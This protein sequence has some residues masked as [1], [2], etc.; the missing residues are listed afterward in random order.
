MAED[1]KQ[2]SPEEV[3]ERFEYRRPDDAGVA[4]ITKIREACKVLAAVITETCPPCREKS[5]AITNLEQV[6]MWANKAVVFHPK[7]A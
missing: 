5:L 4:D 2:G 6:S 7:A 1:K 3:A